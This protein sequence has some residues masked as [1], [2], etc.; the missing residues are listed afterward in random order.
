[1]RC[2]VRSLVSVIVALT[3]MPDPSLRAQAAS[4]GSPIVVFI[5]GRAQA[6]RTEQ[7]LK[8][9]WY[10]SFQDGLRS[11]GQRDLLRPD[12]D[13]VLVLYEDLYEPWNK[14]TCPTDP[15]PGAERLAASQRRLAEVTWTL[16][17]AQVHVAYLETRLKELPALV[18]DT[19]RRAVDK[20]RDSVGAAKRELKGLTEQRKATERDLA[21]AA[22][23]ARSAADREAARLDA[24]FQTS[25]VGLGDFWD[26]LLSVASDV[27]AR[28]SVGR[29]LFLRAFPDT[30]RYLE[31]RRYR[32]ATDGRLQLALDAARGGGRP[33]VLVAHSMGS[34]VSYDLL[35]GLDRG[36]PV[37]RPDNR[38]DVRRLVTLGSQLGIVEIMPF[39]VGR[40]G[41]RVPLPVPSS[42]RS[43]VN[44]RAPNDYVAPR[45][46]RGKYAAAGAQTFGEWEVT[47]ISGDPHSIRGYLQNPATARAIAF[48]WCSAFQ[49]RPV[50]APGLHVRA[51]D[52]CKSIATDVRDGQGGARPTSAP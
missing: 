4:P 42:I 18:G 52:G 44:L 43:W 26:R 35:Y 27:A 33:V 41:F 50:A 51:P 23:E 30:K 46:A 13:Y 24:E 7:E 25:Q 28:F 31:D 21:V 38:Y 12:T 11:L 37:P 15:T 10:S 47:T 9:E 14:P 2:L 32:C 36:Q 22:E 49:G 45:G 8:Q 6:T 3:A 48:A 39:I 16:E 20:V 17:Q 40:E 19:G 29:E 1:M 5:H 34:L